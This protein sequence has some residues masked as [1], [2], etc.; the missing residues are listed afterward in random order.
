MPRAL[1]LRH[2]GEAAACHPD[3][4]ATWRRC[5]QRLTTLQ[6]TFPCADFAGIIRRS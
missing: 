5:G 3:T 4:H 6:R 1:M 2:P